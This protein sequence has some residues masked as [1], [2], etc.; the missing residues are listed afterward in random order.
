M[1][2]TKTT[3]NGQS[4][5]DGE[6]VQ[7]PSAEKINKVLSSYRDDF[8]FFGKRIL[9][10][11]TMES[12]IVKF[13]LNGPQRV[14]HRIVTEIKKVR[15]I[16]LIALKARRMGFSTYF[17]G[18]Y[19]HKTSW[20]HNRYATQVTH[21]PEATDALFKMVKRF[22]SFTPEW[23]RPE[24]L[25]N[26]T[27]LLEFNNKKGR[28]LNSGFRVATAGKEDFGSGQLIHYCHLSEVSKWPA[29]NTSSLLTSILQCV[30]RSDPDSE[31]VFESTAKGIGGEFY[32]RFWGARFRFWVTG[33]DPAIT[34]RK[35]MGRL[36]LTAKDMEK[37]AIVLEQVNSSAPET[38]FYTSIFL[39]WFVFEKYQ[40]RP[41]DAEKFLDQLGNRDGDQYGNE[42]ALFEDKG[43]TLAQLYWR[44]L[45]IDNECNGSLDTFNQEYPANPEDAFI[46]SGRPVFD[47]IKLLRLKEAAPVPVARYE[48]LTGVG[49]WITKEKNEGR[50]QVWEEPRPSRAYVIGADVAEGL[51]KGDYSSADVVDH[52]T[53]QQVAHWHGKVD[54]DQYG[55]I[56]MMLGRR[57]NM[58][59]LGVERNNHGLTTLTVIV[60]SGYQNIYAEMVP[61]PP[62]KPRKRYGWQTSSATRPLIIDNLVR[63]VREGVHG[64][65]CAGTLEEMMSFKIQDNG[66]MEADTGMHD[67]RV[68]S[69]AI[70]KYLRQ[71]IP[72][73]ATVKAAS[74]GF[75]SSLNRQN[76]KGSG[77]RS[78]ID[79]RGWT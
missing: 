43:L 30:P 14:L 29:E 67:D 5:D 4:D 70:A 51:V 3:A 28:G 56:L 62:G 42:V 24:T 32:L 57:Y 18:R 60:N 61:E 58:A 20:N 40:V 36:R 38:S 78:K 45:T 72:V 44:R 79:R 48:A 69:I 9:R 2:K 59:W 73:P 50:L 1:T 46:G 47:N 75:F 76:G 23:M 33:L 55:V 22:Y 16:R 66:K 53:G 21:E 65:R 71:V 68:I 11:Q 13:E 7:P 31:V 63:E 10:V 74:D 35:R 17:S 8:L 39:P 64:V 34:K 54:P 6:Q 52:L 15:P 27:K 41:P 49:Q 19:Y 37:A 25:Y 77:T 12:E 26:N